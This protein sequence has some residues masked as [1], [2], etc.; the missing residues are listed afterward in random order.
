[1][2]IVLEGA[3]PVLSYIPL[4]RPKD[5]KS[6]NLGME[7]FLLPTHRFWSFQYLN[8]YQA[9]FSGEVHSFPTYISSFIPLPSSYLMCSNHLVRP[10]QASPAM[11]RT[12]HKKMPFFHCSFMF[13]IPS[14]KPSVSSL[15]F[16]LNMVIF[17][18]FFGML[19]RG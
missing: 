1:M 9:I 19:T 8:C 11:A 16:P 2:S 10:H 14:G 7:Q 18:S 15:I 5:A 6:Q 17:P 12:I 13:L 3:D 4:S